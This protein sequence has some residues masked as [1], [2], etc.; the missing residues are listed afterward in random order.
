MLPSIIHN[1]LEELWQQKGSDALLVANAQP[2]LRV[3][4]ELKPIEGSTPIKGKELDNAIFE[5]MSDFQRQRFDLNGDADFSFSWMDR[6]RIR[7]NA[8]KQKEHISI[9]LRIIPNSV[10][11]IRELE[12]PAIVARLATEVNRGFVLVTGAT[13]SGKSTTLA[14]ILR[15]IN[16]TRACHIL[17]IEDPVEFLH[18]SKKALV[19]QR[20]IGV[21]SISFNQAL[22]AALREDPDV[23]LVGELRDAESMQ[24]ALT[25]AETGHMVLASL[26]TRDAG[27]AIDRIL[28]V[29]PEG[30]KEQ[31]Q[32][33]LAGSLSA[34]VAQRLV[35][36]IGGGRVASFEVL[37]G[38]TATRNTIREG[39]AYQ[40]SGL[41]AMGR[42]HGM[43][44]MD[45]YLS[46]LV[47]DGIVD[48]N[49]AAP[50]AT[51]Y[52]EFTGHLERARQLGLY[53]GVKK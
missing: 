25:L 53:K 11:S 47:C 32:A 48:E 8:Y 35:P 27:Q 42:Q 14:A 46:K 19:S 21:D 1:H 23:I 3:D 13:G 30:Q 16:E 49:A 43:I 50:H 51:S 31:T 10:P 52:D 24:I 37:T 4:G 34:V 12:L 15:E 44:T 6:A 40:L 26:H 33:Q 38:T 5:M 39:R 2:R 29:M 41:I 45:E 18:E 22:R 20:E 9:A 28:D 7:A 17:T 36:K